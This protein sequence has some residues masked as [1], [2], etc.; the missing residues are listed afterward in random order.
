MPAQPCNESHAMTTPITPARPS[1]ASIAAARRLP[2][3]APAAPSN[4]PAAPAAP[5][6]APEQGQ[7]KGFAAR[8]AAANIAA[9]ATSYNP[10]GE[11]MGTII[12]LKLTKSQNGIQALVKHEDGET[13][14]SLNFN[15]FTVVKNP[16]GSPV[17]DDETGVPKTQASI[18]AWKQWS[19]FCERY[20]VDPTDAANLVSEGRAAET[21]ILQMVERF[22]WTQS[23]T[24]WNV[25]MPLGPAGGE[26]AAAA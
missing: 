26:Q 23:G 17:I 24:F 15:L 9:R 10:G 22:K 7:P 21:G 13:L 1:L 16:D 8:L 25:S 12:G 19:T 2:G 4:A 11:H 20:G 5:E 6:A 14:G 3:T 18:G